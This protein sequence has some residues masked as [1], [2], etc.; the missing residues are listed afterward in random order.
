MKAIRKI[1]AEKKEIFIQLIKYIFIFFCFYIIS[2]ANINGV[3]YPFSFGLLFALMWC[4]NNVLILAPLYIAAMF[5]GTFSLQS[6]YCAI[7]TVIVMLVTY[8][9]H[10]KLKKRMNYWQI[11]CYGLLSQVAFIV[12]NILGEGS[13]VYTILSV[14]F[15][16]LFMFAALK[17]F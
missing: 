4:N 5:L 10:Y 1:E 3:I 15:G 2:K 8:G 7:A 6:L 9:I 11:L 17:I 16:L 14:V 13:I 12:L